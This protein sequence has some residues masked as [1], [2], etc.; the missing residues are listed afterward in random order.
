MRKAILLYYLLLICCLGSAQQKD[1]SSELNSFFHFSQPRI[2][3]YFIYYPFYNGV[4]MI[5]VDMISYEMA[6]IISLNMMQPISSIRFAT[7]Y[8][9]DYVF[10]NEQGKIIKQYCN[11]H[12]IY[13]DSS[14][15]SPK[16]INGKRLRYHVSDTIRKFYS[17]M[18]RHGTPPQYGQFNFKVQDCSTRKFG[19]IDTLGNFMIPPQ[20]DKI[21]YTEPLY[22][23]LKEGKWGLIDSGFRLIVAPTYDKLESLGPANLA[24]YGKCGIV[25][26]NGAVIIDFLYDEIRPARNYAISD[27]LFYRY[28]INKKIGLMGPGFKV[29]TPA[30]FND[31]G[32]YENGRFYASDTGNRYMIL[33]PDCTPLTEMEFTNVP[34][35]LRSGNYRIFKRDEAKWRHKHG[36]IDSSGRVLIPAKYEHV[37]D[38]VLGKAITLLNSKYGVVQVGGREITDFKYDKIVLFRDGNAILML[39]NK[40]AYMD[41]KGHILTDFKYDEAGDFWRGYAR[42]KIGEKWGLVDSSGKQPIPCEYVNIHFYNKGMIIATTGYSY[43]FYDGV[44]NLRNEVIIPF[45]Y[46]SI[47]LAHEMRAWV[48]LEGKYALANLETRIVGDHIYDEAYEFRNGLA[49]VKIKDKVGFVNLKGEVVVPVKYDQAQYNSYALILVYLDG[50]WGCVDRHGKVVIPL[51]YRRAEYTE[52]GLIKLETYIK[53][54]YINEKGVKVR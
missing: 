26:N 9:N 17:L 24:C 18:Y 48:Q 31:F 35:L 38:I 27:T 8:S 34:A 42:V 49:L 5:K 10:R 30:H 37:E 39:D 32:V 23:I 15:I 21:N 40:W 16:A 53:T 45:K 41:S 28:A 7:V 33:N 6:R 51:I 50:Y 2:Q 54:H 13:E 14:F 4:Q 47:R 12:N 11:N 1:T 46:R 22:Y 3:N 52:D 19:I 36:I 20:Y 43:H 29:I 25:D 44:I